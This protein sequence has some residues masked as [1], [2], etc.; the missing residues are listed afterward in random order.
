M[1]VNDILRAYGQE[2]RKQN[3]FLSIHEKKTMRAIELCRTEAL[4]GRIDVCDHCG[5]TVFLYHSCRNRH[6]P[7][8][9]F[10]KKEQWIENKK[11][12]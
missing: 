3:P 5:N 7:L 8:C 10:M 2:Y 12:E 11:N 9:Q 6:C 4:G 1:T